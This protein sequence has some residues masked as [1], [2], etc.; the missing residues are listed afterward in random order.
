M[1]ETTLFQ[2]EYKNKAPQQG[3]CGEL[4]GPF[5]LYAPFT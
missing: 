2:A 5:G 1:R 4:V 3:C